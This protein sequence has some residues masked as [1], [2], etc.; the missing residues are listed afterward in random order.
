MA[1]S[2]DIL[3]TYVAPR[4]VMTGILARGARE[5]Q[6]LAYLAGACLL[7]FIAQW[8]RL[9]R[10]AHYDDSVPFE[11]LVWGALMGWL[12]IAPLMFYGLAGLAHLAARMAG[13]P[14]TGLR[15]RLALF[16][17]LL[18]A[19]PLWLLHGALTGFLGTGTLT[20]LVGLA[21]LAAFVSIWWITM[22]TALDHAAPPNA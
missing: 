1:V 3:R 6:A 15:A 21:M 16:W 2:S 14:S 9:A 19:S 10:L 4:A 18:A 20:L 11:A 8:P 5:E 13:R 22:R 7:I 12:F 17:S